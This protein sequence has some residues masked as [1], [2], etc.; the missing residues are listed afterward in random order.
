MLAETTLKID[1]T[2]KT[3]ELAEYATY[4]PAPLVLLMA[5]DNGWEISKAKSIAN[6]EPYGSV[7]LVT[8]RCHATGAAQ[9]LAIPKNALVEKILEQHLPAMAQ[10]V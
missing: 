9:H 6:W 10:A 4:I 8:M 3:V 2:W 1:Q 7:F 5:L